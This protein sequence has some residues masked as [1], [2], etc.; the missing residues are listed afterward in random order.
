[1]I[2]IEGWDRALGST[3]PLSIWGQFAMECH[4]LWGPDGPV[5]LAVFGGPG[6]VGT[7][8]GV[9]RERLL[10][11]DFSQLYKNHEC[12][13]LLCNPLSGLRCNISI[14]LHLLSWYILLFCLRGDKIERSLRLF[15]ILKP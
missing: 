10:G 13:L 11:E 7:T 12:F 15:F 5:C 4:S 3:A 8:G 14:C 6:T 9:S 2:L 1:M